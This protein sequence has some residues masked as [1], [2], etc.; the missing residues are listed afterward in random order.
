MRRIDKVAG[1]LITGLLPKY[2]I[3]KEEETV[4]R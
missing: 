1:G 2:K 3:I 4:D